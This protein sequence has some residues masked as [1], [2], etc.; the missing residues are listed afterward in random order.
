MFDFFFNFKNYM[1]FIEIYIFYG[2]GFLLINI[3]NKLFRLAEYLN[4]FNFIK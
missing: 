1:Y 2:A 4:Y 3:I